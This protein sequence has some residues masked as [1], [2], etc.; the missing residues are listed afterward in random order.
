MGDGGGRNERDAGG[1]KSMEGDGSDWNLV[2]RKDAP[3]TKKNGTACP[4]T[5]TDDTHAPKSL[6]SLRGHISL[7]AVL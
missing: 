2:R 5:A 7:K 3:I 6:I 4:P 1:E